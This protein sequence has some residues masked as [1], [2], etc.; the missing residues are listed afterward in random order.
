M[1]F[2]YHKANRNKYFQWEDQHVNS[3]TYH[4][5]SGTLRDSIMQSCMQMYLAEEATTEQKYG[6]CDL[7]SLVQWKYMKPAKWPLTTHIFGIKNDSL[8]L[9]LSVKN[10]ILLTKFYVGLKV[11]QQR[12]LV[13][14][15][16]RI[17]SEISTFY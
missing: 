8:Y 12:I 11:F 17:L 1:F 4:L 14:R 13:T 9:T 16:V 15:N 6:H 2:I 7:D 10:F 3:K 5:V